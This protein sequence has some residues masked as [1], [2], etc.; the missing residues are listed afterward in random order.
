MLGFH[1][2]RG[3]IKRMNGSENN[4]STAPPPP[5]EVK[6][7]TMRSDLEAMTKSGG[8]LPRF[9]NVAVGTLSF[10]E[11]TR[12]ASP[13]ARGLSKKTALLI[14]IIV[15]AAAGT[16]LISYFVYAAFFANKSGPVVESA[17][18]APATQKAAPT[19]TA[20]LSTSGNGSSVAPP[21]AA[22]AGPF[23]HLSFFKMPA[24][25]VL[26]L[27]LSP[28]GPASSA[29]DLQ[30]FNQKLT[31]LL[32]GANKN[33]ALIEIKVKDAQG[34]GVPVSDILAAEN[35]EVFGPQFLA[36]HFNPDTTFFVYRDKNGF[37][38]GYVLSL[39]IGENWLFL[40]KDVAK[41]E[42]SPSLANFFLQ[43]VGAPAPGGFTD[44]TVSSTAVRVLTFPN[45]SAP[46]AFTYGWFQVRLILSTSENGFLQA[47]NH[48]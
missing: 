6:V 2:F 7:R 47:I 23:T 20:A 10:E 3:K 27:T 22:A 43:D 37:W 28:G 26:T 41:L 24:D 40:E 15:A 17:Q 29:A 16:A 32:A 9:Q 33:A 42:S 25:Q 35:A 1:V 31:A 8:S 39:A 12:A 5:P 18:P 19:N 11:G 4:P 48:L 46:A 36:A 38:P 45:S 34:N 13:A 30:T 21:P 14:L 44:A